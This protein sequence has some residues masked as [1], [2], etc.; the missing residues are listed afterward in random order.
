MSVKIVTDSTA[1]IDSKYIKDLDIHT[2]PL[3]VNFTDESF[4]ETEVANEYFYNKIAKSDTIPVSSQPAQEEIYNTFRSLITAGHEV[5]GIFISSI[6]SGTYDSALAVRERLL[7]EYPEAQIE[8]LDSRN[9][10]MAL[11]LTVLEAAQAALSGKLITEVSSIAEK[12]I[13]SM[14]FYFCP[15]TLE[16]LKKG[17]RI[18]GASA[19]IGSILNIKPIL[20]VNNGRVDVYKRCRGLKNVQKSFLKLLENF[21]ANSKL[22]YVVVH[23]INAEQKAEEIAAAIKDSFNITP[24]IC[25]IGPVIGTHVGPGAIGIVFCTM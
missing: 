22:K 18:G 11:G 24:P 10:C 17:G 19:L 14:H 12:M 20:F 13:N 9:T 8:I 25:S 5:L 23:H 15:V 7:Q 2:L 16:Y 1:Y 3:Y 21:S 4:K 6:L